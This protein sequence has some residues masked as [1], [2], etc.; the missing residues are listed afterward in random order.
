MIIAILIEGRLVKRQLRHHPGRLL[1]PVHHVRPREI[2][3]NGTSTHSSTSRPELNIIGE[4]NSTEWFTVVVPPSPGVNR[5]TRAGHCTAMVVLFCDPP[6]RFPAFPFPAVRV[7]NGTVCLRLEPPVCTAISEALMSVWGEARLDDEP[8]RRTSDH[9]TPP[10]R[11]T[12]RP[13]MTV[14]P[15]TMFG[16]IQRRHLLGPMVG[17]FV[18]AVHRVA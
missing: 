15:G 3:Q 1:L 12:V 5:S 11:P 18:S 13:R 6:D 16:Y 2:Q 9:F 7:H 10:N 17:F 4:I 8:H 14:P